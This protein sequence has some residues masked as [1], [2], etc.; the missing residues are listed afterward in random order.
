[1]YV[2][3]PVSAML[4]RCLVTETDIPY[5]YQ[6][7]HMSMSY[8]MKMKVLKRYDR[9]AYTLDVLRK[10]GIRA[11]RGPRSITDEFARLL[12]ENQDKRQE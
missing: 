3:A 8:A 9:D 11:V 6:D 12:A 7:D 2:G 5:R 10:C 1:M 4:Y